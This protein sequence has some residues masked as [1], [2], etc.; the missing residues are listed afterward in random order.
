VKKPRKHRR[1]SIFDINQSFDLFEGQ[2][3]LISE[4]DPDVEDVVAKK[5]Y[6]TAYLVLGA[7]AILFLGSWMMSR[8]WP[9]SDDKRFIYMELRALTPK[10]NPLAGA[11][12]IIDQKQVGKTDSFGEWRRYLPA[13]GREQISLT[14]EKNYRGHLFSAAKLITVPEPVSRKREAEIKMSLTLRHVVSNT[15]SALADAQNGQQMSAKPSP[16]KE[17]EILENN[18]DDLPS[19]VK[20]EKTPE[21]VATEM[22]PVAITDQMEAVASET[23]EK[24]EPVVNKE[25]PPPSSYRS[26][27]VASASHLAQINV[28]FNVTPIQYGSV[29]EKHQS[30]MLRT[31]IVPELLAQMEESGVKV[32]RSA[33]WLLEISYVPYRQ[34]VG[35]V[36]GDISWPDGQGV[37][38]KSS[39][40]MSFAKTIEETANNL[41]LNTKSHV[42]KTYEAY[43]K[44]GSWY[45]TSNHASKD[46]WSPS[47]QK[48]LMDPSGNLLSL[49]MVK[50][51]NGQKTWK[52][53]GRSELA[54]QK[55][56]V[57]KACLLRS[58]T[59]D[60]IP[61]VVGWKRAVMRFN[62]ELKPSSQVYIA[63]F[64]A[65]SNDG[66]LWNYW[67]DPKAKMNITVVRDNKVIS[68]RKFKPEISNSVQ[69]V[70]LQGLS[71]ADTKASPS[72]QRKSARHP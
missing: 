72:P 26:S 66:I 27:G 43:A 30:S 24:V 44:E 10:G 25:P 39:F 38:Q 32:S 22:K 23:N 28:R 57:D 68:R 65:K 59:L 7:L 48:Y 21:T 56:S 3:I 20:E 63:G 5:P 8:F 52:L 19:E 58:L 67:A 17:Q 37:M 41:V 42:S 54:C 1:Q 64:K 18:L 15:S 33:K 62:R 31:R 60:D 71:A 47:K 49:D 34:S 29:M 55:N 36:K 9:A 4:S 11:E 16:D 70:T 53:I 12:V 51:T 69:L 61:P 40:I 13:E 35:F 6:K 46:L 50:E 14:M 45:V 2:E